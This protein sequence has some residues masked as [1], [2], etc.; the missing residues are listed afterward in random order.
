MRRVAA[1]LAIAIPLAVA[2]S[3][4]DSKPAGG[5]MLAFQTDLS[6]PKDVNS[7]KV[8]V[9]QNGV[10]KFSNEYKVGPHPDHALSR[11]PLK[12]YPRFDYLFVIRLWIF[13]HVNA[14]NLNLLDA[15]K[16]QVLDSSAETI[17]TPQRQ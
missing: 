2:C 11:R 8:V 15:I 17:V 13:L 9:T 5:L 10:L 14:V 6:L 1:A 7:V 3:S 16:A 4:S 12:L